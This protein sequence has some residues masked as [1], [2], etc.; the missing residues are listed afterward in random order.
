MRDA[1]GVDLDKDVFPLMTGELGFALFMDQDMFEQGQREKAFGGMAL[2]GL[3]DGAAARPRIDKILGNPA[4][5][6]KRNPKGYFTMQA[7][8]GFSINLGVA[9]NALIATTRVQDFADV[10]GGVA[11]YADRIDNPGLSRVLTTEDASMVGSF[12]LSQAATVVYGFMSDEEKVVEAPKDMPSTGPSDYRASMD[13]AARLRTQMEAQRAELADLRARV[14][15]LG[16]RWGALGATAHVS[17]FGVRMD[18]GAYL[19]ANE[20]LDVLISDSVRWLSRLD[21]LDDEYNENRYRHRELIRKA[22]KALERDEDGESA[23]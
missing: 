9:G 22:R 2:L 4:F 8:P 20:K 10:G 3:H 12:D 15:D 11:S 16:G 17:D 14:R 13:E 5:R 18:G 7:F 6:L 19:A 21:E 23:N 1:L